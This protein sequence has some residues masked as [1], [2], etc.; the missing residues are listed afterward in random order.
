MEQIQAVVARMYRVGV[1]VR[2]QQ[3]HFPLVAVGDQAVHIIMGTAG[4]E[5]PEQLVRL[6]LFAIQHLILAVLYN[7]IFVI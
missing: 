1:V 6:L 5:L 2:L 7:L 3:H 4:M